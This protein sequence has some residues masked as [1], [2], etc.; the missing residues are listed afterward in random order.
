MLWCHSDLGVR[1]STNLVTWAV[2]CL[3]ELSLQEPFSASSQDR[4]VM[5]SAEFEAQHRAGLS[6]GEGG[7]PMPPRLPSW[8]TLLPRRAGQGAEDRAGGFL[9]QMQG[10]RGL[11]VQGQSRSA[12]ESGRSIWVASRPS[13]CLESPASREPVGP[14]L[15]SLSP[16]SGRP[17]PPNLW[18]RTLP[19]SPGTHLTGN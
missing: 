3:S 18:L 11:K 19:P 1:P 7:S 15:L 5:Q 13:L 10:C 4:V 6:L 12:A 9:C 16:S 14:V 2:L 17:R 8:S